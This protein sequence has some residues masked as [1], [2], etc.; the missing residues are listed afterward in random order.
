MAILFERLIRHRGT[1][2]R[3]VADLD[4]AAIGDGALR[5]TIQASVRSLPDGPWLEEALDLVV[6]LTRSLVEVVVKG[7]VIATVPFT[8]PLADSADFLGNDIDVIVDDG[9]IEHAMGAHGIEAL[10]HLIPADPFIGC[11]VK[12]AVSTA[13][14]QI[15]RCWRSA[16]KGGPMSQ[17]THDIGSCLR[18]HGLRMALT[19]LYRAG[20]CAVLV[21]MG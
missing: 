6:D 1:E 21:G 9:V 13:I 15:I 20:R 2:Y 12:S 7:R 5:V 19:F 3:I 16:P 14:G 10:I 8:L 17:L 18:E 11:I 4:D